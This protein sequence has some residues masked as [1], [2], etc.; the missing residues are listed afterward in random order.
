MVPQQLRLNNGLVV[1]THLKLPRRMPG[2]LNYANSVLQIT[3]AFSCT[4]SPAALAGCPEPYLKS[5]S[6]VSERDRVVS[7]PMLDQAIKRGFIAENKLNQV[8]AEFR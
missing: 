8:A 3:L 5:R 7:G 4:A 6:G 1:S 2:I